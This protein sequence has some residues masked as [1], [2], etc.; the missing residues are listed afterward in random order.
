MLPLSKCDV[1]RGGWGVSIPTSR[2]SWWP[3][4]VKLSL[5]LTLRALMQIKKIRNLISAFETFE[6]ISANPGKGDISRLELQVNICRKSSSVITSDSQF[7]GYLILTS[8]GIQSHKSSTLQTRSLCVIPQEWLQRQDRDDEEIQAVV[9]GFKRAL[10]KSNLTSISF[11]DFAKQ[12]QWLVKTLK[13]GA[14]C[15]SWSHLPHICDDC[16]DHE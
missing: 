13:V 10:N 2:E 3:A 12:F 11:S 14:V 9:T 6:S 5:V 4:V 15:P 7:V 8:Y 16:Q 1:A